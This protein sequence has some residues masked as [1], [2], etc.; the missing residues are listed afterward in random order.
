MSYAT[1]AF[2]PDL[3]VTHRG[4]MDGLACA[5]LVR[6]H[7]NPGVEIRW[8]QYGD[9]DPDPSDFAGRKLLIADFS[10]LREITEQLAQVCAEFALIDHH[11]TARKELSGVPGCQILDDKVAGCEGVWSAICGRGISVPMTTWLRVIAARDT[12]RPM[13]REEEW[14]AI[15]MRSYPL[16]LET[17]D[18]FHDDEANGRL[19]NREREGVAIK[20]YRDKLIEAH[21]AAAGNVF[22]TIDSPEGPIPLILCTCREIASEVAKE[23]AK[24]SLSGMG[25]AYWRDFD[26]DCFVVSLRGMPGANCATVAEHFGGGGHPGAAGFRTTE[27]LF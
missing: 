17:L 8:W 18:L 13:T 26:A 6:E 27:W 11:E 15:A 20:R 25:G 24:R 16:E 2:V 4:C 14:I 1:L 10:F 23:A 3:L 21:V 5:W 12:W 19:R 7:L 22:P 9:A